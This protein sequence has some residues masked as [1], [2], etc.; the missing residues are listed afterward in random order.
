[1]VMIKVSPA[2]GRRVRD[3][4]L[5]QMPVI[6]PGYEVDGDNPYW[7]RRIAAGDVTID[8]DEG[9]AD[10]EAG[11]ATPDKPTK[12]KTKV[13]PPATET[14]PA[15]TPPGGSSTVIEN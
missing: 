8:G 2:E 5:P 14:P 7:Y 1:M 10:D 12:S 3:A 4:T 9:A 15:E 6:G 11:S 13:A